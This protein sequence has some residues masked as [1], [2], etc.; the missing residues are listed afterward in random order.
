MNENPD[1]SNDASEAVQT[2][3]VAETTI[4]DNEVETNEVVDA[5]EEQSEEAPKP[6][7]GVAKGIEKRFAKLTKE[8]YEQQDR[9]SALEQK[10]LEQES[11]KNQK[12]RSEYTDDE[13]IDKVA[14]DKAQNMLRKYEADVRANQQS[15]SQAIEK[16]N[17]WQSKIDS[18][19]ADIPDFDKVLSSVDI[20]L[21]RDVLQTITESDVGPKIAY[22]LAKNPAEA[23]KLNHMNQRAKDRFITRLEIKLEDKSFSKVEVTKASPTPRANGLNGSSTSTQSIDDWMAQR[24]KRAG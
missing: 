5:V 23:D 11:L 7:N 14:T 19:K 17:E 16:Q 1:I 8:K 24:N 13:W 4:T 2:P 9:I 12:S 10:L 18:H 22:H 15:Q 21:P 3:D 6:D 20:Q